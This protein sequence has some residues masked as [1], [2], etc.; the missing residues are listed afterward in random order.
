MGENNTLA[1]YNLFLSQIPYVLDKYPKLSKIERDNKFILAGEIDI[2][3]DAGKYWETYVIEIFCSETF[4][5]RFPHLYEIGGKIPKIADWHIYE[6]TFSCCVKILPEEILRCL[7]GITVEQYV[8]SEV[9]PYL[10][11][12]THRRVEGYYVNGEY[13]H[14]GL[15]L[16]EYYSNEFKTGDLEQIAKLLHSVATRPNPDR[17]SMCFCGSGVKYRY[18][19]RAIYEKFSPLGKELL[20]EHATLFY[21]IYNKSRRQQN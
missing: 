14:G 12:Q 5:Y 11:N 15:G 4:P 2:I 17:T 6:D 18:C 8:T 9:L 21:N 20:I 19:H 3:D 1:A 7:K 10:F 16:Y 13:G